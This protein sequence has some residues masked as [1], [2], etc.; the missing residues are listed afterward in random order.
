MFI[1]LVAIYLSP[2]SGQQTTDPGVTQQCPED[3]P[4]I[5]Y[6]LSVISLRW[7]GDMDDYAIIH[8]NQQ[9]G[10]D[11]VPWWPY[12]WPDVNLQT[13]KAVWR[14][15]ILVKMPSQGTFAKT[16]VSLPSSSTIWLHVLFNNSKQTVYTIL[17]MIIY[18]SWLL[19]HV[20]MFSV[21]R[22]LLWHDHWR[23]QEPWMMWCV[24]HW[25]GC[26]QK[27]LWSMIL[28]WFHNGCIQ[29]YYEKQE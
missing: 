22:D 8:N 25:Q 4:P 16:N 27:V 20:S 2:L 11:Y 10:P 9:S 3:T 6:S 17:N 14:D 19:L 29:F 5:H 24:V 28:R 12:Q 13:A 26:R 15:H 7:P 23:C 1:D 21:I 18:S